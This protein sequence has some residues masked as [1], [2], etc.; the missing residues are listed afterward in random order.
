[1]DAASSESFGRL[2]KQFRRSAELTQE[3][4]AERAGYSA[5]YL[6]KLERGERFP[7][8][9]TVEALADALDLPPAERARLQAAARL[10]PPAR[11]ARQAAAAPA[12]E[13]LPPVAGRAPELGALHQHLDGDGPPLLLL[14]GEPG[15]GKTR[16]LQEVARWG[17]EQ[18]RG[19][20]SGGCHRRSG[21]EPYAPFVDMLARAIAQRSLAERAQALEGCAWLVRLLPELA[22]E[23][24]LAPPAWTSESGQERRLMFAA[25]GRF[26]ANIADS[27]GTILLL[28]DLQWAG[29][30]ALD[31]L[32][33]LLRSEVGQSLRVIGAYRLTETGPA[34]PL[35]TLLADLAREGL[36]T[37]VELGP[38]NAQ[39]ATTLLEGLL[40]DVEPDDQARLAE[41]MLRRAGGVPYFLVSCA[42][43]LRAGAPVAAGAARQDAA[44]AESAIPWSVA[45]SIRQRVALLPEAAQYLLGAAAV[46]GREVDRAL[47]LALAAPLEW[48]QREILAALDVICQAR[49]LVEQGGERYAFAHDLIRE[50]VGGDLSAARQAMLHQQ[51]A[52]ALEQQPGELPVEILAYHYRR[53]GRL[54]KAIIYLERSGA[55]AQAMYAHAEAERFYR[56]LVDCLTHLGRDVEAIAAQEALAQMLAAQARYSEALALLEKPLAFFQTAQN[57]EGLARIM[58]KMGQLQAARGAS[59]TGIALIEPWLAALDP[60]SISVESRIGLY[61]TLTYLLQNC[62]RFPEALKVAEQTVAL[63]QQ[64]EH[65]RLLGAACWHLGR[66]LMLLNRHTDALPHLENALRLVERAGDLRSFYFVLLNLNLACEMLGDLHAARDYNE[67]AMPLAEQMG[68]PSMMAHVL[69][70][71]GYNAFLLG[72]WRLAR[73]AFERA[74]VF[75]RQAGTPW[76][77]AYPLA[78]LGMLLMV[79]GQWEASAPYFEEATT[80]AERSQSLQILR[81]TQDTLA[82]REL[83]LGQPR[84]A[85]KRL[86]PL[87]KGHDHSE[88]GL[89][90]VQTTLAW[91]HLELG[92]RDEARRLLERVLASAADQKLRVVLAV[93]LPVRAR[94]AAQD[95]HWPEAEQ[96]LEEAL[97]L[98]RSMDY[99]YAEAKALY[100]AGLVARQEGKQARAIKRLQAALRILARLGERLYAAQAEEALAHLETPG[101]ASPED[102]FRL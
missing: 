5:I 41:Q 93:A 95:G 35:G 17:R 11:P 25:V 32:A 100:A 47:L 3:A 6:R 76:G 101:A 90:G 81:Y 58:G 45:E 38:L 84:A 75:F 59:E 74:S 40:A 50:V 30:D 102:A 89:I 36:V 20:L 46:V 44:S 48:G 69:N 9:F 29:V 60:A 86:L 73:E 4:L 98:A 87:L 49:L 70:T 64:I 80:L 65:E 14:A 28:D 88:T 82:E 37:R 31:L 94:L 43:E 52:E 2:L 42:Q 83:L 1:M 96:A 72:E 18:G 62:G 26:L 15:I 92:E 54:E 56:D 66:G 12:G 7:L 53:A 79:E 19:V 8:T 27:A 16:L 51:V 99:P 21:Q 34:D 57:L 78:N 39:E 63:A 97:A 22:E 68:D 85:L 10:A 24:L 13:T 91:A 23:K 67:R 71:R 77:A 61:T 33:S 55:R